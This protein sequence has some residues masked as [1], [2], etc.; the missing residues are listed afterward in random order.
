[1]RTIEELL[2]EAYRRNDMAD[3]HE[4]SKPLGDRWLG[5]GTETAYRPAL[6][7]GL[8]RFHNGVTPHARVMGWLCLT[9]AGVAA[10]EGHQKEFKKA[11]TALKKTVYKDSY[12]SQYQLAG[13]IER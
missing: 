3:A 5:L 12:V 8:F 7:A 2:F 4:R 11:L 13:G 9:N 10:M 6:E 1:M